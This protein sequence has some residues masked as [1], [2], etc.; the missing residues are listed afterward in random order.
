MTVVSSKMLYLL[1]IVSLQIS[2][3]SEINYI[4]CG[5]SANRQE[6]LIQNSFHHG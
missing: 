1:A 4:V 6:T 5:K 2:A 3:Y